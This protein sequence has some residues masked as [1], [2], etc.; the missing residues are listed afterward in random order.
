VGR[1]PSR[2]AAAV[3]AS[4]DAFPELDV[5][6]QLADVETLVQAVV[7]AKAEHRGARWR[8]DRLEVRTCRR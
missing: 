3:V 5:D 8:P 7:V 2:R 1:P 6:P 4:A